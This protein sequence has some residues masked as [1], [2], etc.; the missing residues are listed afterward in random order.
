MPIAL[1]VSLKAELVLDI[2]F[3]SV[4]VH[5]APVYSYNDDSSMIAHADSSERP[6]S[7]ADAAIMA[8]A[9]RK[10]LRK[11]DSTGPIGGGSPENQEQRRLV[12]RKLAED[13]R[14]IRSVAQRALH[15]ASVYSPNYGSSMISHTDSDSL[16][17]PFSHAD[18][19]IMADA[20][21]RALLKT[22]FAS[23][24]EG[25][26]PENQEQHRP[27]SRELAEEGQDIVGYM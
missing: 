23:P 24:I 27:L 5:P 11:S 22:D 26:N 10:A 20:F 7:G 9:F 18:A 16:E 3:A 4:V 21:R 15:P 6:F 2:R 14:D 12:S 25:D 13:G 19:A 17:Q 1:H 8:D